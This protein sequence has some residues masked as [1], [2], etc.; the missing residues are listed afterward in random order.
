MLCSK[1][2]RMLKRGD[3]RDLRLVEELTVEPRDDYGGG[4]SGDDSRFCVC[5]ETERYLYVPRCFG[6]TRFGPPKRS[7]LDSYDEVR[8][9]FSG[10][11]LENQVAP[12]EAYLRAAED[13]ARM[14]GILQLP[15]GY[16]KTVI[17]L[18]LVA[19]LK[20]KTLI[21][22]HKEFLM[23]QWIERVGAYLPD[24]R[25]GIIKQKR[26]DVENKDLVIGLVQ[27][28]SM[29]AYDPSVFAGFGM[30]V[31]DEC[32]HVGASVF[33]KA[34]PKVTFRYALGLSAT[35]V[36]KDGL[37]KV[38]KWFLGDV[39]FKVA[40][41]TSLACEVRVAKF[42]LERGGASQES[43]YGRELVM[44]NGKVNMARMV[45]VVAECAERSAFVVD[46]IVEVLRESPTRNV[47]VLSDRRQHLERLQEGLRAFDLRCGLYVGGMSNGALEESKRCKV[48]LGTY[49]MVSEGFDL[50]RLDT[51]VL[52]TSKSDVEQSVGRI[53]RKHCLSEEDNVPMVIDVLDDYS[54]F[55]NQF[56][57]RLR[58]Y[59]KN[60]Y[61]ITS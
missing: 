6:L 59:K 39:V 35:V 26:V 44:R 41:K 50:A 19:R 4:V 54:V 55:A 22:V 46:T 27:S 56:A 18:Y 17:A 40:R 14:G 12:V 58:F 25:V 1:G 33:S 7:L 32:H 47:I 2:Y 15:P 60:A 43:S 28:V 23:N 3:E 5:M 61:T 48:I 53:Q 31:V 36:R 9:R 42:V 30:V 16:G 51:L 24:C 38:F 29:R 45:N 13:P 52:A 11:L 37:T 8:L 20:A 34:L 57:R 49:S 21:L 10:S